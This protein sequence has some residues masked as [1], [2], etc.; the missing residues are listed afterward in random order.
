MRNIVR[1]IFEA[2]IRN[3]SCFTFEDSRVLLSIMDHLRVV[4]NLI[5]LIGIVLT[6]QLNKS[7]IHCVGKSLRV[8]VV[9][10]FHRL[11]VAVHIDFE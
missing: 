10:C 7:R 6:D 9:R 8:R 11:L 4:S 2:G 3:L 5:E 1:I